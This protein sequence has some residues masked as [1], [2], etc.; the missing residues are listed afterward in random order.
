MTYGVYK[1]WRYY[2]INTTCTFGINM[3]RQTP[4]ALHGDLGMMHSVE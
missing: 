1:H 2:L 4:K 3:C